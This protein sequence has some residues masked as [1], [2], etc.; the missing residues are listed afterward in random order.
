MPDLHGGIVKNTLRPAIPEHCDPDW[1]KL[2]EQCWSPHPETRPSF[3]EIT[4][5]LR[6]I[7]LALQ[8][9]GL[10]NQP[11]YMKPNATT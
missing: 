3:T 10:N 2:M 9:K 1:R 5:R 11:R 7:S 6:S 8:A 4:N